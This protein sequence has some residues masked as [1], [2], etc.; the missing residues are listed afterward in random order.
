[1]EH[2][3]EEI[4]NEARVIY[5]IDHQLVYSPQVRRLRTGALDPP[6]HEP[7]A[8]DLLPQAPDGLQPVGHPLGALRPRRL[9]SGQDPLVGEHSVPLVDRG[10]LIVVEDNG[11]AAVMRFH[12]R[13]GDGRHVVEVV[14]LGDGSLPPRQNAIVRSVRPVLLSDEVTAAIMVMGISG[15]ES[16]GLRPRTDSTRSLPFMTND[17]SFEKA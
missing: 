2:K 1:M 9:Q 11:R 12:R 7:N 5:Q 4:P 6:L 13:I 17:C 3:V 14:M 10:G 16:V 8:P 15:S